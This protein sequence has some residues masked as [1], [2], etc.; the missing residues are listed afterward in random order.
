V[1][2]PPDPQRDLDELA[3]N[4]RRART[5]VFIAAPLSAVSVAVQAHSVR[6]L[7][8]TVSDLSEQLETRSDQAPLQ[9][10]P[11]TTDPFS[12]LVGLPT[13]VVGVLFLIWFHRAAT[14]AA[15]LGRPARRSP[16]WAVGGWF[17][18]IGNLFLP[19]QSA[20]D[21]FRPFEQRRRRLVG[22]WWA[23]YLLAGFVSLPLAVFAGFRDEGVVTAACV[24]LSLVAWLFAALS[25]AAFIDEVG[26]S[27]AEDVQL[28]RP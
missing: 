7:R 17:I 6:L 12:S 1:P 27:L 15:R 13:I 14:I 21:L 5:A 23:A 11:V 18:P 4:G 8:D 28:S 26:A 22:R 9:P 19:Y 2:A 24:G 20:R 16:G 10:A 3:A 25:A